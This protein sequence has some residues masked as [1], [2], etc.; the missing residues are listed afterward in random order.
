MPQ[1][2]GRNRC[3]PIRMKYTLAAFALCWTG[4]SN[5]AFAN[6][7]A[8]VDPG[9]GKPVESPVVSAA[10]KIPGPGLADWKTSRVVSAAPWGPIVLLGRFATDLYPGT[11]VFQGGD[12]AIYI[13]H[14]E[15]SS[16][17][18]PLSPAERRVLA[19]QFRAEIAAGSEFANVLSLALPFLN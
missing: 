10:A 6:Q 1:S 3:Y 7:F 17:A 11:L 14:S 18:R 5:L 15:G 13:R 16:T 2:G 19:A 8:I 4:L 12:L 9:P